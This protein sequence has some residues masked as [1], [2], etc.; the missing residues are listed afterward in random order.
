MHVVQLVSSQPV[1]PALSKLDILFILQ[2]CGLL[3]VMYMNM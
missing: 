2:N 1:G 3:F